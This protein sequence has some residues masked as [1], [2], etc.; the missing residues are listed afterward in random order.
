MAHAYYKQLFNQDSYWTI[1]PEVVVKK[2]LTAVAATWLSRDVPNEEIKAALHR[3]HPDQAPGPD[4]YN[5]Y[6]FQKKW[7]LIG[8]DT[9]KAI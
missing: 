3:M 7:A 1:F 9:C 6:F 4:R 5:V 2:K 8:E